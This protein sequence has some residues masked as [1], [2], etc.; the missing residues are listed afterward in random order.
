MSAAT[1]INIV[2]DG[3]KYTAMADVLIN[4]IKEYHGND[5]GIRIVVGVPEDQAEGL[6]LANRPWGFDLEVITLPAPTLLDSRTGKPYRH[7]NKIEL[8]EASSST[9]PECHQ[10]FLDSDLCVLR[11]LPLAYFYQHPMAAMPVHYYGWRGDWKKLYRDFNKRGYALTITSSGYSVGPAYYNAGVVWV[12]KA[13]ATKLKW[14]EAALQIHNQHGH[15]ETMNLF[16]WLDQLSLPLAAAAMNIRI[17][18]LADCMN[19]LCDKLVMLHKAA[20]LLPKSSYSPRTP[21]IVHHHGNV[22]AMKEAV[23]FCKAK[24]LENAPFQTALS[25]LLAMEEAGSIQAHRVL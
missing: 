3:P 10:L 12:H 2:A 22:T 6:S 19:M 20:A 8:L 21:Y 5:P 15:D 7:F 16:P 14:R 11:R 24:L 13:C 4:S 1:C 18:E 17:Y 23:H 25:K 9:Y